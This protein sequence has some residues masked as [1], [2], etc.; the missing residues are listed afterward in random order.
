MYDDVRPPSAA[1]ASDDG[2]DVDD[3]D[4]DDETSLPSALGWACTNGL[5][6]LTQYVRK[7][8]A[9]CVEEAMSMCSSLKSRGTWRRCR[10]RAEARSDRPRTLSGSSSSISSRVGL[11][12]DEADDDDEAM[13]GRM[14][15][16]A[17]LW[18][19]NVDRKIFLGRVKSNTTLDLPPSPS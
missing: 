17:L 3:D 8:T 15:N 18:R 2:D 13:V 16:G 1:T 7:F 10:N 6:V 12:S 19:N 11:G 9:L 14:V 5:P 4:D